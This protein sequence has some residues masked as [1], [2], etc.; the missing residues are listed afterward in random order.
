MRRSCE[1]ACSEMICKE[2]RML[3]EMLVMLAVTVMVMKML[4][5]DEPW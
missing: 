3:S 4:I 1:I 2:V 5:G